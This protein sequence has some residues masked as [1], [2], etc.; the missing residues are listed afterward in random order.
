MNRRELLKRSLGGIVTGSFP[1]INNCR[2]SPVSYITDPIY[3]QNLGN[4]KVK[5]IFINDKVPIKVR[6]SVPVVMS[7]DEIAGVFCSFYGRQNRISE[8]YKVTEK[9]KKVLVCELV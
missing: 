5:T 6:N 9:T 4:K 8:N 3:L 1:L 2:K 7:S